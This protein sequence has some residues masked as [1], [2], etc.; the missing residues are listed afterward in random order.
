MALFG[1][2]ML[3]YHSSLQIHYPLDY[4]NP[5]VVIAAVML[6]LFFSKLQTII[7]AQLSVRIYSKYQ[8][9]L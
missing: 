9:F 5:F 3:R 6:L 4:N 8:H 1:L 2:I 7:F